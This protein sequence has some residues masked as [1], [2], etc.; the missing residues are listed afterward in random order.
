MHYRAILIQSEIY[1]TSHNE[2]EAN[3]T[4]DGKYVNAIALEYHYTDV[5]SYI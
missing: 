1:T 2:I 5:V 4:L 3:K